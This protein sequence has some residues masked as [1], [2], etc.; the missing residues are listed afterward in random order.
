MFLWLYL[1]YSP[2]PCRDFLV[3]WKKDILFKKIYNIIYYNYLYSMNSLLEDLDHGS[4]YDKKHS[5]VNVANSHI[6]AHY[7]IEPWAQSGRVVSLGLM[8]VCRTGLSVVGKEKPQLRADYLWY[9]H[10]LCQASRH[11]LVQLTVADRVPFI[12]ISFAYFPFFPEHL[13]N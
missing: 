4:I 11:L 6:F 2:Q 10:W 13:L 3:F 8:L 1:T 5:C 9:H 12:M 7:T